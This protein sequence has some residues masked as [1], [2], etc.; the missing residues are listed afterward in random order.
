MFSDIVHRNVS[1]YLPKFKNYGWMLVSRALHCIVDGVA[2]DCVILELL[3]VILLGT[4]QEWI[5]NK[6]TTLCVSYIVTLLTYVLSYF[7]SSYGYHTRVITTF[8]HNIH[9]RIVECGVPILYRMTT[10]R[11]GRAPIHMATTPQFGLHSQ[12][13][14]KRKQLHNLGNAACQVGPN[15]KGIKKTHFSEPTY[16]G[17]SSTQ[18]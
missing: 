4:D 5:T 15:L 16:L 17:S 10:N 3:M 6:L 9:F 7:F 8:S 18:Q 1:Y 12:H 14:H 11:Q 13:K 2:R